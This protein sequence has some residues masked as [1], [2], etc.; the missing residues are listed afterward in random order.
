M[1]GHFVQISITS[2]GLGRDGGLKQ[3]IMPTAACG[4]DCDVC[5]LKVQGICSTCSPGTGIEA[6]AKKDAQ[7]RI[8]GAPCPILSCAMDRRVAYCLRDCDDFPCTRFKDGPYPFGQGYLGMQERRRR[9]RRE[10]PFARDERCPVPEQYWDRLCD[11][12]LAVLCENGLAAISGPGLLYLPFLTDGLLIDLTRRQVRRLANGRAENETV[13]HGLLEL[14]TLVYLLNATTQPLTDQL[15]GVKDLKD[16]QFFKGLHELDTEPLLT[17]YGNDLDRLQCVAQR[18]GGERVE[19][20]DAAYRFW[21]FPR[22][23][24][25]YLL[26]RRDEEFDPRLSILF[27]RSIECHLAADAIWGLTNLVSHLLLSA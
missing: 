16:A 22:V 1:L 25:Y 17:R 11:K 26:W 2:P 12:D 10:R 19:L 8:L 4:I 27:D 18:F 23:P 24:V 14:L 3:G 13:E 15:V 5:R 9:E 6:I 7:I 20:A 21:P